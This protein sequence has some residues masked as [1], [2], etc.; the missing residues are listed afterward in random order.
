RA[1]QNCGDG[2]CGFCTNDRLVDANGQPTDP[3]VWDARN[4]VLGRWFHCIDRAIRWVDGRIVRMEI[5]IDITERKRAEEETGRRADLNAT[6]AGISTNLV[7]AEH[8][9]LQSVVEQSILDM[10]SQLG[11]E[12]SFM[13]LFDKSSS[14]MSIHHLCQGAN[15]GIDLCAVPDRDFPTL[16]TVA[17]A[18]R[19]QVF[20]RM[21]IVGVDLAMELSALGLSSL[22]SMIL[23]PATD[24]GELFVAI[25]FGAR[26]TAHRWTVDEQHVVQLLVNLVGNALGRQR[27]LNALQ[28]SREHLKTF[29]FMD[30]LTSLANR[31]LLVDR[32]RE[33]AASADRSGK[34][35]AVCYLDLD[36]FKPVNDQAGHEAGDRLLRDVANR[37]R[38]ETRPTD[39]VAR[40]GGDEFAILLADLPG[41]EGCYQVLNRLQLALQ[42][43]YKVQRRTFQVTASI[44][45][46]LYPSDGLNGETLLRCADQALYLAKQAG[47]NQVQFFDLEKD[48]VAHFQRKRLERI[49]Q[50]IT[51]AELCLHYQPIVDMR[52]GRLI[53]VEALVRWQHPQRGLL[54]PYAFLPLVESDDLISRLDH[55]VLRA[56][57]GDFSVWIEAGL[58]LRLSVNVAARS[59][60][61]AG[62]LQRIESLLEQYPAIA[63]KDIDLEV[64]EAV[65]VDHLAAIAPVVEESDQLGLRFVID[66][67]GKGNA[68]L[69]AFRQLRA[70]ALKID[71]DL[72]RGML[73]DGGDLRQVAGVIGVARAFARSVIAKGLETP[74]QGSLLLGLGCELAQGFFIA[75]P[76]V[77]EAIPGWLEAY[78]PPAQWG[79]APAAGD[80][81][82]TPLHQSEADAIAKKTAF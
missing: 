16:I 32:M 23:A 61:T 18:G 76:M 81:V 40:W 44:G 59:I 62:F 75:H 73:D 55:W 71:Q 47:G 19:M 78:V 77:A 15:C 49:E 35:F 24:G 53:G 70:M 17:R 3:Y 37:L 34:M 54:G 10:R 31:R 39:T 11:V 46:S 60:I 45:V 43:P 74:E 67:F 51:Q 13:A 50:A 57:L 33:V 1:I 38:A 72:V 8:G 58:D 12:C 7:Q 28:S 36:E 2:P 66:D 14:T 20:E 26:D 9:E 69:T 52:Q 22:H 64:R 68:S 30:P 48:R 65:A 80:C 79:M 56:A 63:T 82:K 21:D 41:I 29:A 42:Q 4:T 27:A 5:A 6:L 25:G